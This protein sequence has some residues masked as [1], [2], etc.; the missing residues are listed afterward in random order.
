MHSRGVGGLASDEHELVFAIRC[1]GL[2]GE[3][4]EAEGGEKEAHKRGKGRV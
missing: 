3:T 2:S 4:E 1:H